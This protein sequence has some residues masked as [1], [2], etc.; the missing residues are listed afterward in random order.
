MIDLLTGVNL[1]SSHIEKRAASEPLQFINIKDDRV[2]LNRVPSMMYSM[3]G[4]IS[5]FRCF[6][7][8]S[9]LVNHYMNVHS[10]VVK[11]LDNNAVRARVL[12]AYPSLTR[13]IHFYFL[14]KESGLFS[15]VLYSAFE[16]VEQGTDLT[17]G[18]GE[19]VYHLAC[20]VLTKRSLEFRRKKRISRHTEKPNSLELSLDLSTGRKIG[21][22]VFF[23]DGHIQQLLN[24]IVNHAY[25]SYNL[26][27]FDLLC[28]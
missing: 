25:E 12:R 8:Q 3:W 10:K 4:Y 23:D 16:D 27:P 7:T 2:E 9:E 15:T 28:G 17:V 5:T 14:V 20:Y 13:E 19:H 18:L 11:G 1:S 26:H 6:P 22:M 21:N 24:Q